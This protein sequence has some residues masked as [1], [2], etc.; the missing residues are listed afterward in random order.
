MPAAQDESLTRHKIGIA[1]SPST[2]ALILFYT[3]GASGLRKR[4]MPV[5]GLEDGTVEA[6]V[7]RVI[8]FAMCSC[9]PT[10]RRVVAQ[11][12]GACCSIQPAQH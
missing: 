7:R 6:A 2:P 10:P 12:G 8:G 3:R 1:H 11:P 5:R 4:V 9:S